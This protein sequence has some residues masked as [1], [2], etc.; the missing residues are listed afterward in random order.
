MLNLYKTQSKNRGGPFKYLNKMNCLITLKKLGEV[1]L[2]HRAKI[3]I[4]GLNTIKYSY[5]NQLIVQLL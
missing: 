1:R 5:E 2:V 3:Q 4:N